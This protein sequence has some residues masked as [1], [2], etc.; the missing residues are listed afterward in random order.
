M[1]NTVHDVKVGT[2]SV[3]L[4][5]EWHIQEQMNKRTYALIV[6]ALVVSASQE[7]LSCKLTATALTDHIQH[8]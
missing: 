1:F 2:S 4:E 6:A 8:V 5:G 7:V 3:P